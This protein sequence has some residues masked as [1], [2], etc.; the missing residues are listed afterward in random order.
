[1]DSYRVS[2][3][4][5][6][7]VSYITLFYLRII[8]DEDFIINMRPRT[9]EGSAPGGEAPAARGIGARPSSL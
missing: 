7:F 8:K 5:L 6:W 4:R 1:M 3:Q 9:L 2:T